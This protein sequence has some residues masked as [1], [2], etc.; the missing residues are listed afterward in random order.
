MRKR[1]YCD[2]CHRWRYGAPFRFATP[3]GKKIRLRWLC[4][5]CHATLGFQGPPQPWGI[6]AKEAASHTASPFHHRPLTIIPNQDGTITYVWV[7]VDASYC[8]PQE[9][10]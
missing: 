4:R 7:M 1:V 9:A 3:W 8:T 6:S 10:D 2:C 5:P